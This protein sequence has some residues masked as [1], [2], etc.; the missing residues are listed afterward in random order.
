MSA[1]VNGTAWK[2]SQPG[3]AYFMAYIEGRPR[4]EILIVGVHKDIDTVANVI[5]ISFDFLP[6]PG[7]YYF[8]NKLDISIDSGVSAFYT[9]YDINHSSTKWSTG[10]FVDV[11]SVSK[12]EITGSFNFTAKGDIT[13]STTSSVKNGKFDVSFAGGNIE[14]TGP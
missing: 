8:N 5:D 7:R 6:K 2:A 10:G 14:W 13:D 1:E 11:D 12:E 4:W 3:D 9:Y